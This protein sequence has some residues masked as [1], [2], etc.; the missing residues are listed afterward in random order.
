MESDDESEM[1]RLCSM[2]EAVDGTLPESSPLHEALAKGALAIQFAF[3]GG[4]RPRIGE[5]FAGLQD[6]EKELTPQQLAKLR[7]LG[8]DP[9]C[10]AESDV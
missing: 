2:L 4:F 8:I 5:A 9:N 3:I 6:P 7:E 10:E 1:R